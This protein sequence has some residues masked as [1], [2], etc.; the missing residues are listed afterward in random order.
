[1]T[2]LIKRGFAF[3]LYAD[4]RNS[5]KLRNGLGNITLISNSRLKGEKQK[6]LKSTSEHMHGLP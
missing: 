6:I 4:I 5:L 2:G 3:T 1:M